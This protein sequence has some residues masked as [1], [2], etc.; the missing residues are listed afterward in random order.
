MSTPRKHDLTDEKP[1]ASGAP[2]KRGYSPI[3]QGVKGGA[4]AF[5]GC[6]TIAVLALLTVIVVVVIIIFVLAH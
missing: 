2:R 5:T 4:T 3:K 6:V 1:A